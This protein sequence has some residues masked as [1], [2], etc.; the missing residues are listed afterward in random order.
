MT[1]GEQLNK[2]LNS[3]VLYTNNQLSKIFKFSQHFL[4]EPQMK[5]DK[6]WKAKSMEIVSVHL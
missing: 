1:Y 3:N 4:R 5:Q 2:G 6:V